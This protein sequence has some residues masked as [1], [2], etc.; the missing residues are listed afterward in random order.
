MK[1]RLGLV[2]ALAAASCAATDK[3]AGPELASAEASPKVCRTM[4]QTG[5]NV[6]QKVCNTQ[7]EWDAFDKQG[8]EETEQMGRNMRSGAN[9][10]R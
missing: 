6:P 5:S 1:V 2:A 3:A 7:T 9:V 4:K 8:R 10:N